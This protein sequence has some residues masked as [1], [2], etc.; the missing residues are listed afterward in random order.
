MHKKA[1]QSLGRSDYQ[2]PQ[3]ASVCQVR[4]I[5]L[6]DQTNSFFLSL[7]QGVFIFGESPISIQ[8]VFG[9]VYSPGKYGSNR[10][11]SIGGYVTTPRSI[12]GCRKCG[13]WLFVHKILFV[14][15]EHV[16]TTKADKT[17]FFFVTKRWIWYPT[18]NCY[19]MSHFNQPNIERKNC[20]WT[21]K[22]KRLLEVC[23]VQHVET[24]IVFTIEP[25]GRLFSTTVKSAKPAAA[26]WKFLLRTKI[27]QLCCLVVMVHIVLQEKR[28]ATTRNKKPSPILRKFL[29]QSQ[30]STSEPEPGK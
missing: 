3:W 25:I 4:N 23:F 13:A 9:D 14:L 26:F 29:H 6:D 7:G 12:Y 15:Q 8:D 24:R 16:E 30:P 2:C 20:V 11:K 27:W 28:V 17:R 18:N 5:P 19:S 21:T 10:E 1:F 22:C